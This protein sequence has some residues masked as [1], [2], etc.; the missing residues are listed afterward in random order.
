MEFGTAPG[1][2]H[3]WSPACAG[4][5]SFC[6]RAELAQRPPRPGLPPSGFCPRPRPAGPTG[7]FRA[8]ERRAERE[9]A[10]LTWDAP[11][12]A[13]RAAFGATSSPKRSA[14]G[15]RGARR[16]ERSQTQPPPGVAGPGRGLGAQGLPLP[17]TGAGPAALSRSFGR[18]PLP[19]LRSFL[20]ERVGRRLHHRD[21]TSIQA[22]IA[23]PRRSRYVQSVCTATKPAGPSPP[24]T[25]LQAPARRTFRPGRELGVTGGAGR[26]V[27]AV[28]CHAPARGRAHSRALTRAHFQESGLGCNPAH[29]SGGLSRPACPSARTHEHARRPPWCVSPSLRHLRPGPSVRDTRRAQFA[30]LG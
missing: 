28:Y 14:S 26:S 13:R 30:A 25:H 8:A 6:D 5:E 18:W 17:G 11:P 2:P 12:T 16:R 3:P 23:R 4:L 1:F 10:A 20:W 29:L 21:I 15:V 19:A 27:V 7:L 24:P 9:A 22:L